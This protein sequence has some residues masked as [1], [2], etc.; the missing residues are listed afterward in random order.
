[1]P[2]REGDPTHEFEGKVEV[3]TPKAHLVVPT[4][5]PAQFWVPKSQIVSMGEADGEGNRM[6]T[7]T[8]WWWNKQEG[9]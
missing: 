3:T 4:M 2:Y 6:F 5:G 9:L 7:V 1:M 8:S